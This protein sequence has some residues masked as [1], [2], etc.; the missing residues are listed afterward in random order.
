MT[1]S[2]SNNTRSRRAGF[3]LIEALIALLLISV[4][5]LAVSRLQVLSI[6]GAG[7]AKQYSTAMAISQRQLE[8]LRNILLRGQ[9]EMANGAQPVAGVAGDNA[10][11]NL[12]WTVLPNP[13]LAT[14]EQIELRVTTTWTDRNGDPKTI[15]L[16]SVIAWDDP[17]ARVASVNSGTLPQLV[18]PTGDAVRGNGGYP[19][20]PAGAIA[21]PDGTRTYLRPDGH[22][23]L[24][25]PGNGTTGVILLVLPPKS[26]GTENFF[27]TISGKVFFDQSITNN[28]TTSN[29]VRL[30]LSSEGE[31]IFDNAVNALSAIVTAGSNS[32]RYFAYTCYV[33]AGWYGN[34]G[35]VVDSTASGAAASP[36][37]CVGDPQ[38]NGG[39]T[40]NTLISPHPDV[41]ATRSYRGFKGTAG[42]YFSTGMQAG[43]FYG[44]RLP[45]V[46]QATSRSNGAPT[47]STYPSSYSSVSANATND[48]FDQNFLVTR[49][50]GQQM[51]SAKMAGGA[52]LQ[53]A[54]K[55]VCITPDKDTGAAD[56][57][58]AI[59]PNYESQVGN[60]TG[61]VL[62]VV[63]AGA[64][65]GLVTSNPA[66]ISCGATCLASFTSGSTI[67]LTAAPVGASVFQG[68]SGAGCSGTGTCTVTLTAAASVTATFDTT[69]SFALSVATSGNGSGTVSSSPAGISCPSSCSASYPSA[70]AVTLSATPAAGSSFIGWSGGGCTGTGTCVV[71]MS[72]AQSVTAIF[73]PAP[74]Y[75]LTVG[76]TGTGTGTVTSSP[77]G[78]SCGASC[79]YTFPAGQVV[80]LTPAGLAG[81]T[82]AGWTGDCTGTGACSVTMSAVH[83]VTASF[84]AAAV[85]YAV[86]VNKSGSGTGTVTSS[87]S[88]I[89][90]GTTCTASFAAGSSVTLTATA[91]TGGFTGWNGG[92]CSGTGTCTLSSLSAATAVTATFGTCNTPISGSAFDKNGTVVVTTPANAGTCALQGN[93]AGYDC[94][95]TAP[96]GTTVTLTNARTNGNGSQ[97]YS[98]IRT[99]VANCALQTPINFGP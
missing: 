19:N 73:D 17:G 24:I 86:T 8:N 36:T 2:K 59:W 10:T 63:P 30:R 66:G 3:V 85:T 6:S 90:C 89:N 56:V 42:A 45:T 29:E 95:L 12:A 43:S 4:G 9:F 38:F 84:T 52:F 5:L 76:K 68:W 75:S 37:I 16:N 64:G 28:P 25:K 60:G 74:T 58:P 53:N 97:N 67:T 48:F 31:C 51:C 54:G 94:A 82:F 69:S 98:Y 71:T 57:C 11:Y 88:G 47:P 27:A 55:Y 34:V 22:K 78:V 26:D 96:A 46:A 70:T 92:G 35:V 1:Q 20:I 77:A 13:V 87:P 33:G 72:G 15:D 44:T 49:I 91:L 50:S 39:L 18:S 41:S 62:T 14:T 21:N 65:T 40:N 81:S 93:T 23:E 79:T 83:N 61:L 32:Y 80:T 7:E 99:V